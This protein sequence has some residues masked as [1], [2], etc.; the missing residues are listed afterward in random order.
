MAAEFSPALDLVLERLGP[1][2][3][4]IAYAVVL[5]L[6]IGVPLGVLAGVRREGIADNF[7][8]G[9]MVL[10]ISLPAF[11]IGLVLLLIFGIWIPIFPVGGFGEGWVGHLRSLFLPAA[12][13]SLCCPRRVG[14]MGNR[15]WVPRPVNAGIGAIRVRPR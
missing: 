15:D 4:L 13:I 1:E 11:W 9:I 7:I 10:G 3:F 14:L 2:L 8:R 12:T 6:M 5:S